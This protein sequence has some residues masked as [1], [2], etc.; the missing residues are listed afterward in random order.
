MEI[1]PR[2][3]FESGRWTESTSDRRASS[4]R[5]AARST[6]SCF[7][8]ASSS[9]RDQ[10]TIFIPSAWARRTTSRP[11]EPTPA[12][13]RVRPKTPSASEKDF[14]SHF[15]ARRSAT[16]S[17]MRR[18]SATSSPMASSATAMEFCP[19]QLAT[20]T[21]RREAAPTSMVFTP[22]PARTTSESAGAPAKTSPVTCL[23]RTTRMR[24]SRAAAGRSA[25]ETVGW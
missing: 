16:L 3:S 6:P 19:G 7:A 10:A 1:A 14:L 2:V 22:A 25:T 23:P 9:D 4:T 8:A 21:P 18:S 17:G 24:A 5:S 20:Y 12:M 13:P 15:P 11:I